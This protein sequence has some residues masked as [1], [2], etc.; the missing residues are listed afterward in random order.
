MN[1]QL[2]RPLISVSILSLIFTTNVNAEKFLDIYGGTNSTEDTTVYLAEGL[3]W[4][5]R[6]EYAMDFDFDS[7]ITL[8][9]RLG[10]WLENSPNIGL[11][12]DVSYFKADAE[13]AE[14][15][16]IPLS[17]L[18]MARMPFLS[19][20]EFP[21]GRMLPY[22]AIGPSVMNYDF[23][24]DLSSV[25]GRKVDGESVDFGLDLRGGLLW[26]V[27]DKIAIFTEYRYTHLNVDYDSDDEYFYTWPPAHKAE[28]E[29]D[30]DTHHVL[31]GMSFRY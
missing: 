31:V 24:V 18:L 12:F 21:N 4:E 5:P 11:A 3:R 2:L 13:N 22:L 15:T 6:D 30:I 23:E 8:G 28:V 25:D 14:F 17:F 20:E 7:D 19:S 27:T 29:T 26:K 9:F 10:F 16:I 1:V